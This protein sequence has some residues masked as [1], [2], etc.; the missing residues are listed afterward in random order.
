[1]D[2][3]SADNVLSHDH[4]CLLEVCNDRKEVSSAIKGAVFHIQKHFVSTRIWLSTSISRHITLRLIPCSRFS[5]VDSI[6][7]Q[8]LIVCAK[9]N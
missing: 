8:N 6:C 9:I 4:S 7:R 3:N 1:M 2:K 5:R